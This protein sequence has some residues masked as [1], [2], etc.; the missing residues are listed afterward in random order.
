MLVSLT[1]LFRGILEELPLRESQVMT[2]L[3]EQG[4]IAT[5]SSK[6]L[7][8]YDMGALA[9]FNPLFNLTGKDLVG[10]GNTKNVV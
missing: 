9:L 10:R 2:I 1:A 7:L 6:I 4:P 8:Q 3:A 5:F